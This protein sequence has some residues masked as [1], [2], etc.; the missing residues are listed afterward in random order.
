MRESLHSLIHALVEI[1]K[2]EAEEMVLKEKKKK[3]IAVA[4]SMVDEIIKRD[5]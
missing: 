3:M 5:S 2:L 4:E 1:K